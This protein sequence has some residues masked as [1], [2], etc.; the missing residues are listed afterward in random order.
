[1]HRISEETEK[2]MLERFGGDSLISLATCSE[3]IP[4]VRTVNAYYENGCFYVITHAKSGKIQQ[5]AVNPNAA[6]C[7][8]WFTAHGIGENLGHVRLHPERMETLR[9]VFASWYDNGHVNEDDPDTVLLR[10]RLTDGV[11]FSHGT[12]Y[13][14]DF[15]E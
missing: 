10:I 6:L 12:R 5:L 15:T 8:D 14:L 7:G 11:L 13:D 9:T 2:V 4:Y 1:M 3:N